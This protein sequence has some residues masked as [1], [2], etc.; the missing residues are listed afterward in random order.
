M[1]PFLKARSDQSAGPGDNPIQP[2]EHHPVSRECPLRLK[3]PAPGC[4]FAL[5]ITHKTLLRKGPGYLFNSILED[6][7]KYQKARVEGVE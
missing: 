2:L 7:I 3:I 4:G 1:S 6:E 5:V